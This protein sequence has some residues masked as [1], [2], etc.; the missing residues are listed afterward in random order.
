MTHA[1]KSNAVF[2]LSFLDE[3][4]WEQ[5]DTTQTALRPEV[6]KDWFR[7]YQE[8]QYDWNDP[9]WLKKTER[10]KYAW[11]KIAIY[12][13]RSGSKKP[14]DVVPSGY[15]MAVSPTDYRRMMLHEDGSKKVFTL[16]TDRDPTTGEIHRL[17]ARRSG[18]GDEPRTVRAHR[19]VMHCLHSKLVVD[20][21]SGHG[22][23]NRSGRYGNLKQVRPSENSTNCSRTRTKNVDLPKGVEIRS[24][25]NGEIRYG[26]TRR[27]RI[28]KKKVLC[29]RSKRVWKTPEPAARWYQNQIKE[30][31]KRDTWCESP[32]PLL[33]PP[34]LETEPSKRSSRLRKKDETSS[35]TKKARA[36]AD[37]PF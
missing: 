33:F 13:R 11:R 4:E 32:V 12:Q 2:D 25:R 1:D 10:G 8:D 19:E 9:E 36:F 29:I 35:G 5:R 7:F 14:G 18:R 15:F 22:L 20:H 34:R 21:Y 30:K 16:E 26:G 17:Y 6:E 23:D 3:E 28:S 31:F 37:I 27:V 24:R